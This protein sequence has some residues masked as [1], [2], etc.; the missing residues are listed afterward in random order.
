MQ[1]DLDLDVDLELDLA[2]AIRDV[3]DFPQPGIIF[4]DITTL[5]KSAPAFRAS[6][7]RLAAPYL[8]SAVDLVIGLESRGFIFGAPVAYRLGAGFVPVR[9][10]GKLPAARL[11]VS[12]QLE[13]GSAEFE[14][15]ADAIEPGQRVLLIDDVL[16]T[17]GTIAAAIDLLGRLGAQVVGISVLAELRFLGGRTRLGGRDVHSL[18]V[19]P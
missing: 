3:P 12:Y 10:A 19:Y 4:K 16:A 17:G 18:I 15:H 7:D 1:R 13:Y 11:G 2:A 8:A 9:K 14:I 6:I 5:L